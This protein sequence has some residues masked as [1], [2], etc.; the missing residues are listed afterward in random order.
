MSL[1]PPS[2][3]LGVRSDTVRRIIVIDD[4]PSIHDDFRKILNPP[5]SS[6]RGDALD[7]L[8]TALFGEPGVARDDRELFEIYTAVQG[9]EGCEVVSRML[10]IG[11][12]IAAAFVDMRMPPGWD[13]VETAAKLWSVDPALELAIC[14]AY[15][16]YSWQEVIG[17]LKRPDLRLLRKPFETREVLD[18]AWELTN[19]RLRRQGAPRP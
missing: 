19:R 3:G 8:E 5:A 4:N 1:P 10:R 6:R 18:L 15:S 17:T 14:S 7:S 13:G 2:G 16:D 12:P 11:R 9:R